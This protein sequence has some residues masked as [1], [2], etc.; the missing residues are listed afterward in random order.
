MILGIGGL[1]ALQ[2]TVQETII[3]D[4]VICA[5]L[6][7]RSITKSTNATIICWDTGFR[8]RKSQSGSRLSSRDLSFPEDDGPNSGAFQSEIMEQ[9]EFTNCVRS[10]LL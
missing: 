6:K 10:G 5:W 1:L 7:G 2:T 3:D 4:E 9:A 8:G